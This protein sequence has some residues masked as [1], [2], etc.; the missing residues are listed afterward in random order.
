VSSDSYIIDTNVLLEAAN[1]YYAFGRVPAFWEWLERQF[2]AGVVRT[3][4]MVKDEVD[5]PPEVVSWVAERER[6]DHLVDESDPKIQAEYGKMA[7]WL[8][9]QP[10]GAEHIASFMSKAD[11]W[12]IAVAKVRGCTVV[13]QE[14]AAGRGSRKVRIPDVCAHFG[15]KCINTFTLMEELDAH[16]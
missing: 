3:L 10:Y 13:T 8:V 9:S 5:F 4:T 2:V 16:L 11:L 14:V 15:I 6:D 1:N 12:I 7:A